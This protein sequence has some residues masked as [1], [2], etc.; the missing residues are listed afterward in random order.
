MKRLSFASFASLFLFLACQKEAKQIE[1]VVPDAEVAVAAPTSR[2]CASMEVLEQQMA[3]DPMRRQRLQDIENFTQRTISSGTSRL[4]NGIMEIPVVVHV[5]YKTTAENISASQ[6]AS[7]IAV[8]NEDF[9]MLNA[10]KSKVPTSFQDEQ[11]AMP[12]RF[13][14]SDIVRKKTTK[15]SW[16]TNDAVKKSSLGGSNP[17][18]PTTTL[19]MWA[20]NL[21]QGLL[22]YAQFP[23][24]SAATD[25]VVILY[26]AFGSQAKSSG[27]YIQSYNLGRTAT[28]EVGHWLNLRHIWGDATCGSDLVGDTP[29]HNTSNG[30]CPTVDHRSTCSNTPVEMTMNYMDYTNDACMYMFSNGQ[31]ARAMAIFAAGGPRASFN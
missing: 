17:I 26:S 20:C 31:K 24:G 23:G 7:Q 22:G 27:T 1:P 9:Q 28:H 30:G 4:V 6:I 15:K 21:G 12:I 29:Q 5:V 8:L 19:N 10:D 3:A 2:N 13:V 18:N 11:T 16:G 14:L 25:G